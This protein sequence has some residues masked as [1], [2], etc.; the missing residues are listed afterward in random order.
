MACPA[1]RGV[2][3][4]KALPGNAVKQVR[5][6]FFRSLAFFLRR[7]RYTPQPRVS[8]TAERWSATLGVVV[9]LTDTLKALHRKQAGLLVLCNAF[10][11]RVGA[12]NPPRV[13]RPTT[14]APRCPL[15]LGF[16]M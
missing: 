15:T 7:R 12:G 9:E 14:A 8:Y 13:A 1:K 10:S 11:V 16:G 6:R 2:C 4:K 3:V 5:G